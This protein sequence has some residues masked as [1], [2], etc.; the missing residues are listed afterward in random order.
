MDNPLLLALVGGILGGII[1]PLVVELIRRRHREKT[2]ARPRKELLLKMLTNPKWKR[3][4]LVWLTTVTGTTEEECRTLLIELGARGTTMDSGD[5]GWALIERLPLTM[6]DEKE[7][8]K[9]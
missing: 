4:S 9:E 8:V 3:R 2:W 6:F 7:D 5:E 1:S